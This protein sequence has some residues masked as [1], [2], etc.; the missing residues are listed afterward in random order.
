[1]VQS[2]IT[3]SIYNSRSKTCLLVRICSIGAWCVPWSANNRKECMTSHY[4]SDAAISMARMLIHTSETIYT[5]LYICFLRIIANTNNW[6][7]LRLI[8]TKDVWIEALELTS[9]KVLAPQFI[10]LL[11]SAKSGTNC[12]VKS[13]NNARFINLF[14]GTD[15]RNRPT[16]QTRGSCCF[17]VDLRLHRVPI[18]GHFACV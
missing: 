4:H 5:W 3:V 11:L 7:Y 16:V 10:H 8:L 2:G 14:R 9:I 13:H 18:H 17:I 15:A 12:S 6:N 1:M